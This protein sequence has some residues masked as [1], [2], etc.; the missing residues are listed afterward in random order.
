MEFVKINKENLHLYLNLAHAYEAEFSN[1]T[2]KL[3]TPDGL[4]KPDTMPTDTHA[5]YLLFDNDLPVGFCIAEITQMPH[6]ICEFYIAP[7][8]RRKKLGYKLAEFVFKQFPGCW[9][10]RQIVGAE[11]AIAFWRNVIGRLANESCEEQVVDDPIWG[12]VTRQRFVI[13]LTHF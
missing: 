7:V 10:V 8:A 3:P 1:L 4:F 12:R 6:D 9:Q 11:Q 2:E 5:S 13:S